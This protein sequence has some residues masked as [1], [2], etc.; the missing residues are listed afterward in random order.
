MA[1]R[2]FDFEEYA[3]GEQI[4]SDGYDAKQI[5][6]EVSQVIFKDMLKYMDRNNLHDEEKRAFFAEAWVAMHTSEVMNIINKNF[7]PVVFLFDYI[8]DTVWQ[9]HERVNHFNAV[10]AISNALHGK[11]ITEDD[12]SE[13]MEGV[14]DADT[15]NGVYKGLIAYVK[16]WANTLPAKEN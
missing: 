11:K 7:N 12:I 4:C 16:A 13:F 5:D 3:A 6:Y 15:S 10:M 9:S 14:I 8:Y 1:T 2:Y